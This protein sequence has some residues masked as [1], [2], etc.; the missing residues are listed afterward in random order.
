LVKGYST[1]VDGYHA[2]NEILINGEWVVVDTTVDAA[3]NK[4]N[5]KFNF[6][7]TKSDYTKVYE[8]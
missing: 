3:Y 7:K 8:Y 2:W 1:H 6:S 5:M 4:A